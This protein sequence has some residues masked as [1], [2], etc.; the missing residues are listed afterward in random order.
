VLAPRA[1]GKS[2]LMGRAIRRLRAD[3]QKAAVVDLTQIGT[4][5][6]RVDSARWHYSI[7]YRICR[8]LRLKVD[9]QDWWH[10]RGLLLNEQRLVEFFWDIVLANTTGAVTI[11]FDEAERA[12]DL[13]FSGELFAI[14]AA[15]RNRITRA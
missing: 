6:E 2:S 7:A 15:F 4:R 5:S 11:F 1:T 8:E 9:L 14:C 10:E 13:A 12:I 3:G